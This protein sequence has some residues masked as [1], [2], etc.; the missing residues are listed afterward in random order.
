MTLDCKKSELGYRKDNIVWCIYCVNSFKQKMEKEEI[1]N[2]C[3]NIVKHNE[4][5]N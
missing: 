3:K 1:I 4:E 2:I 5:E